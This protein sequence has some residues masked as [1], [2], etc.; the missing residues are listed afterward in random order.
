MVGRW[1]GFN[2]SGST[3][4]GV[5]LHH[6]TVGGEARSHHKNAVSTRASARLAAV[7]V[8]QSGC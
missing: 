1:I 6:E 8:V 7:F 3:S 5:S 2:V 4:P